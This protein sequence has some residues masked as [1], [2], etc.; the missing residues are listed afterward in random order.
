MM[1]FASHIKVQCNSEKYEFS[2]KFYAS[3]RIEKSQAFEVNRCVVLCGRNIGVG[4]NGLVQLSAIINMPFPLQKKSHQNDM[5]GIR[6]TARS[7]A[8]KSMSKAVV[9][10]KDFY[11]ES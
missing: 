3:R 9:E 1:R 6:D 10:T 8:V 11:D 2:Y 7:A 4:Y 5:Q